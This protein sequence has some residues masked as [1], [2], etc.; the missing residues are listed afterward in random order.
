MANY[1]LFLKWRSD[2]EMMLE[3]GYPQ[4]KIH[5]T[6]NINTLFQISGLI[7]ENSGNCFF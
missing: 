6:L 1:I 7:Y 3:I 4:G 5:F 2:D